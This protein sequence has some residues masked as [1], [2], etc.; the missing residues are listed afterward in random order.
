MQRK[1]RYVNRER[2]PVNRGHPEYI[3]EGGKRHRPAIAA[4]PLVPGTK[5]ELFKSVEWRK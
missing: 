1:R 3:Q 5:H 2:M 4:K